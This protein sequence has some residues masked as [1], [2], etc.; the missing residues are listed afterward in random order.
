MKNYAKIFN[1]ASVLLIVVLIAMQFLPFWTFDAEVRTE[2]GKETVTTVAS[3]A[4]YVWNPADCRD[5][6]ED[7]GE[8]LDIKKPMVTHFVT[9]AVLVM[10][11]GAVA[12]ILTLIKLNIPW[13][14][15]LSLAVGVI[16]VIQFLGQKVMQ[17]GANWQAHLAVAAVL[18]VVSLTSV[19]ITVVK[20]LK[21]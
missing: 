13:M 1:L 12:V 19:V 20:K 6:T 18:T 4:K 17:L 15:L 14:S 7:F 9:E 21:K 2:N 8:I 10:W 5:L 3:I 16:G 11:L